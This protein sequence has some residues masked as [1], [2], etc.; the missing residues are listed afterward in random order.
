M[1]FTRR[2]TDKVTPSD[3]ADG[4]RTG[5]IV[6]VDVREPG[7]REEIRPAAS[8]HIP[9]GDLPGRLGELPRDRT[10]AFICR[11]GGRS[12]KATQVATEAGMTA[13]NV[14]GG[15]EAWRKAGLDTE[16]GAEGTSR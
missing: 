1:L 15:M 2:K 3:A 10:V 8:R 13:L 7:E 6:L 5:K 11:S 16:S 9:L 14:S 12:A 4:V